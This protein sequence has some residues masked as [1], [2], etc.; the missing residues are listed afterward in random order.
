M[1][2]IVAPGGRPELP[3]AAAGGPA[4]SLAKWAGLA[5]AVPLLVT[6]CRAQ[7]ADEE[8]GEEMLT[9]GRDE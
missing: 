3:A 9:A 5:C 2:S 4:G 8:E 1:H 6:V 7:T